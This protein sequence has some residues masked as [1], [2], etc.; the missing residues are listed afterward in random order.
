MQVAESTTTSSGL[1]VYIRTAT[2]RSTTSLAGDDTHH[3]PMSSSLLAARS[4]EHRTCHRPTHLNHV[5]DGLAAGEHL[6]GLHP[7]GDNRRSEP[8]RRR[9]LCSV[10][11]LH[12]RC[13]VR[14]HRNRLNHTRLGSAGPGE[15]TTPG[16]ESITAVNEPTVT[17]ATK[18]AFAS[19]GRRR[20]DSPQGASEPS[21]CFVRSEVG[22]TAA[23]RWTR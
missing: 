17:A 4:K 2:R 8:Q 1:R 6:H 15:V 21:T 13:R 19:S 9:P 16:D 22:G 7:T 12:E 14:R 18:L 11:R 5:G 23:A 3:R 10:S 20:Q